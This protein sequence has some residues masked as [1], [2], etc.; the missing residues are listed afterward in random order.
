MLALVAVSLRKMAVGAL[1]RDVTVGQ[2]RLCLLV[3][4]LLALLFDEHAL[5]VKRAEKVG[6]RLGVYLRG[7]AAVNIE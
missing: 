6:R 3:V 2:E 1:A 7:G 5:V 4:V